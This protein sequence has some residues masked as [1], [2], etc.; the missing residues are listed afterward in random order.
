MENVFRTPKDRTRINFD[1]LE[2]VER[3]G[4]ERLETTTKPTTT[5]ELPFTSSKD[6]IAHAQVSIRFGGD[7]VQGSYNHIMKI[8]P[9]ARHHGCEF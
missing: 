8:P 1:H 5:T 7:D 6:G 2:L 4:F 3:A 9:Q